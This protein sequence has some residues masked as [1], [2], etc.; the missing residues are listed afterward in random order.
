MSESEQ[1]KAMLAESFRHLTAERK[2]GKK[3]TKV[4]G[5][6][7]PAIQAKPLQPK[8]TKRD[9]EKIANVMKVKMDGGM[10]ALSALNSAWSELKMDDQY[11]YE[12]CLRVIR[13]DA[14]YKRTIIGSGQKNDAVAQSGDIQYSLKDIDKIK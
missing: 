10:S 8:T 1:V 2:Q 14:K 7:A 4:Q 6:T 12:A 13:K 5:S 11:A 9:F 3:A